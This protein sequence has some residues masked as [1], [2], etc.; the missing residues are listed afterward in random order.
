ME[1]VKISQ[2]PAVSEAPAETT[3]AAGGASLA[4]LPSA[5][6]DFAR[7]FLSLSGSSSLG[8]VGGV[9][10]VAASTAGSGVHLCPTTSAGGAVALGAAT[11]IP[12]GASG[13][14]AAPAAVPSVSGHQQR[15]EASCSGRR[16]R[17]SSS[18]GTDRRSKKRPRGKSPS[19]GHSSCR[20]EKHYRALPRVFLRKTEPMLL[21]P[22]LDVRLEVHLAIFVPLLQ[23]AALH[24]LDLWVGRRG[25]LLEETI[26]DQALFVDPLL[27]RERRMMTGRVRSRR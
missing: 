10:G 22:E 4:A 17:R 9:A 7:F 3:P 26:I 24:D 12:D 19:P 18:D 20:R 14:P 15:Q 23:G 1:T 21:L 16:R 11:A 2:A 6:Q 25:R 27:P 13:P 8:A 5:V